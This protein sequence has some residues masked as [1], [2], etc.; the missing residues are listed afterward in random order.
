MQEDSEANNKISK[1]KESG[2]SLARSSMVV[3]SLTFFSRI[4]GLVREIVFAAFFGDSAQ[5]DAFFV[6]F[7]IPNFLRRLFAEGAFSQA[8]VPVLS[9][10]KQKCSFAEIKELV[11]QV[12]GRL[13]ST[14]MIVSIVGVI[15][16]PVLAMVFAP[17]YI[18]DGE[19]FSLLVE[20][21]RITFPYILLISLTGFAG[22]ILNSYDR[23]AVPAVTPVFLNISLIVCAIWLS[24]LFAEPVIAIAWGVIVAGV[25]QLMFQLPFLGHLK[26]IPRPRLRPKH[27]GVSRII[28]LM[29]PVMFAVSV[30]QINLLIDTVLATSIEGD[31]S[32]SWLYYADRIMYLPL[33]VFAVAI[34]TVILPSLSRKHAEDSVD[35]FKETLDW[36]MRC[37]VL[38]ALPAS[39]ALITLAEPMVITIYQRGEF[40]ADSVLP[41]ARALQAYALGLLAF[42]AIKVLAS[43]YFSRQDTK[44]P[45]RYGIIAMVSNIVMNL[46]LIIP[47]AHIGLAIATAFSSWV[48]AGLLLFGLMK[49][50]LFSFHRRFFVMSF[51]IVFANL[52]M[53]AFLLGFN[54]SA[55]QWLSWSSMARSGNLAMLCLGGGICYG[56]GLLI[57]GIRPRDFSLSVSKMH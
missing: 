21:L 33:G 12:A 1:E 54:E 35:K 53:L 5:A 7:R 13:S 55:D 8:F 56:L 34:A 22:G 31:G 27:E 17:G 50:K 38:I 20:M 47:L 40:S 15:G 25:I 30:G 26:L 29:I 9:E 16:A 4:L 57:A 46:L 11:D 49:I 14:L 39:I 43:A 51:Q 23:F 41:T 44:T 19:K 45:V 10:Y 52:L 36:G 32:V 24:P 48:N 2:N 28:T 37:I 42:M 18:D 6:A 3:S